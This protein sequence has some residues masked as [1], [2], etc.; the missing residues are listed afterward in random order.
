MC[1]ACADAARHELR[2]RAAHVQCHRHAENTRATYSTGVLKFAIF[3][4]AF[5]FSLGVVTDDILAQFLIFMAITCQVSTLKVYL[6]AIRAWVLAEGGEFRPVAQ[7]Y[8]VYSTLMGLKR[9]QGGESTRKL[10]VTPKMLLEFMLLLDFEDPNHVMVWGAM[11]VAFFGLFRKD[12]ITVGKASAFNP[13]ANLTVGDFSMKDDVMWVRVGHSKVIQFGE[14]AHWVPLIRM[15]GH[16][17][18]PVRAAREVLLLHRALGSEPDT[19]MFLWKV[20]GKWAP[21]THSAFVTSFKQLVAKSGL[22]WTKYS[23]H[24]FRRGGATYCFNL[25]VDHT[26]IK[27]LGDWSSDAYLLYDETT[28]ARRLALPQAMAKAIQNGTL[29]HGPRLEID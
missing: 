27:L 25:G 4:A 5:G 29:S 14:R 9:L 1:M 20:R 18:C 11:V 6:Y 3:C 28:E 7:R 2:K 16:P 10:A 12:N 26:L 19:P 24:S 17:L 8:K 23:G 22:D 15:Q 21:M 13:R